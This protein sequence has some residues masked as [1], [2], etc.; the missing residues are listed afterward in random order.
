M[1]RG[2]VRGADADIHIKAVIL[3]CYYYRAFPHAP[4]LHWPLLSRHSLFFP[5]V[6]TGTIIIIIWYRPRRRAVYQ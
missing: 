5:L 6:V 3:I 1:T 4:P 2:Y